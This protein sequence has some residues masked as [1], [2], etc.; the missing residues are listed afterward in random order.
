MNKQVGNFLQ[1]VGIMPTIKCARLHMRK[2]TQDDWPDYFSYISNRQVMK[3][4][5]D[6]ALNEEQARKKFKRVL[7]VN[8]AKYA[9]GF[10]GAWNLENNVFIGLAKFDYIERGKAE[11][12]YALLPEYW[13]QGYASEMLNGMVNYGKH[14]MGVKEL[15][16]LIDPMNPRS[17]RVLVRLGFELHERGFFDEKRTDYYKLNI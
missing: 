15:Y 3:Y 4:I 5:G 9:Y 14:L 16:G 11:V 17:Q 1:K 8:E 12:G 10:Y 6:G 7:R 2:F 13:G